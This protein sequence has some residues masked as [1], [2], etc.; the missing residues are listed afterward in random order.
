MIAN[1]LNDLPA[2][3]EQL[4]ATQSNVGRMRAAGIEVAIG[5]INDDESAAGAAGRPN[6]P[7]ISSA[8]AGCRAHT[9]LSWSQAFA[10]DQLGAGRGARAW[11]AR[12]ARF[13]PAGAATW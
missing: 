12:S 13:G 6:M 10:R 11:A 1:A 2:T 5:M 7:A 3:F 8:S 9:G 4:A